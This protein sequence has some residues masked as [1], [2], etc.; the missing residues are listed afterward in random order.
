[1]AKKPAYLRMMNK[2]I[3]YLGNYASSRYRLTEILQ[4]FADQKLF[5]YN[6]GEVAEALHKTIDDC[7]KLGYLDD[8]Q[9]A[10]ITAQSQRR[11]GRSKTAI[12]QR[13]RKHAL[14]DETI[15][16]ALL[17][18]DENSKDG[19]LQAAISFARRRK[20]GPFANRSARIR[21]QHDAK[22]MRKRDF[23]AMGRA[24][25][26]F[27]VALQVLDHDDPITIDDLLH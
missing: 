23:S 16:Y 8:C 12:K 3:N 15:S 7:T 1:M 2:A 27:R 6:V 22:N 9:F 20:L 17:K 21:L 13:L 26:S 19:E 24:G 18:A 14:D 11:L 25:F 4:R 5:D 10:V